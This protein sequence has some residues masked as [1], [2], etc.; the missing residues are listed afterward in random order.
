MKTF[1]KTAVLSLLATPLF[2]TVPNVLNP[3]QEALLYTMPSLHGNAR[4]SSMGGAFGALGGNLSALSTN[5]ASIGIYRRGEFSFTPA[6][7]IGQTSVK[8]DEP[9]SRTRHSD[10]WNFNLGNFGMVS[11]FDVARSD[12]A[13]EWKMFQFGFG[14][15]RLADFNNRSSYTRFAGPDQTFL[16]ALTR[17]ANRSGLNKHTSGLAHRA[18]LI[19]RDINEDGELEYFNDLMYYNTR[20][21]AWVQTGLTQRQNTQ[22]T[23][24]INEWVFSFGGNYG[25]IL[26]LGATIGLPSVNYR[27]TRT[28]TET[29]IDNANPIFDHWK[30]QENLQISG[31]G[32]NLKLGAIV[33]PTD[34]M[35]VGLAIHTPTRFSLRESF[36]TEISG[37]TEAMSNRTYREGPSRYEY[38]IR[39][40]MRLIGSLGFV[41][42]RQ[43]LIGIEYEHVNYSRMRIDDAD[44]TFDVDNDFIADHFRNGG[45]I[46]VGG[47]YRIHPV[48]IRLGYNYTMSPYAD[49]IMPDFSGRSFSAGLGFVAGSTTIDL[50]YVNT[51]RQYRMTPYLHMPMNRYNT[52]LHQIMV[53]FGWRF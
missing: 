16:D 33:R 32:V 21:S 25:D 7:T 29:D 10:L 8:P 43:A 14:L 37:R 40:P 49:N 52:S 9:G 36:S 23:G 2:A 12:A 34:F 1:L 22:T 19:F 6:L 44:H 27:Q 24:G 15:N 39:T 50:A 20:D 5:P 45:T 48:S 41:I 53:T 47:E 3:S 35:R 17:S 42:G 28:L 13:N 46:K 31:M 4:F 18:D 11:V 51:A 26:Y 38:F 30:F